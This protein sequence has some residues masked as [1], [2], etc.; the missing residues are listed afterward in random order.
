MQAKIRGLSH[1]RINKT[2]LSRDGRLAICVAGI[3]C[4]RFNRRENYRTI[5]S[6]TDMTTITQLS[7]QHKKM[8]QLRWIIHATAFFITTINGNNDDDIYEGVGTAEQYFNN[9]SSGANAVYQG[10]DAAR[11]QII[12]RVK[13]NC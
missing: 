9:G 1:E 3:S 8:L 12:K 7:E 11:K 2:N 10:Y 4:F 5:E 13:R 6:G